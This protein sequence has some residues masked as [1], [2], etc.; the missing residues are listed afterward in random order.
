[1]SESSLPTPIATPRESA[2][3]L[4]FVELAVGAM[5]VT[6]CSVADGTVVTLRGELD[7]ASGLML[8]SCFAAL[9][10]PYPARIV[11]DLSDVGFCDCGGLSALLRA[12]RRSVA[13]DGWMRLARATP[14]VQRIVRITKLSM[15]LY[16]YATVSEAFSGSAVDRFADPADRRTRRVDR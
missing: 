13:A 12:R 6:H 1:M 10:E 15:V 7:A 8:D 5:S 14:Q 11:I 2:G 3:Q 16:C 9:G 4:P